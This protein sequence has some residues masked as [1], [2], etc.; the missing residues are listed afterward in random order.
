MNDYIRYSVD[1]LKKEKA[2]LV[3]SNGMIFCYPKNN[4]K[5]TAIKCKELFQIHE[6]TMCF[7]K[8]FFLQMGGFAKNSRGEGARLIQDRKNGVVET[9]IQYCM[10]CVAHDGNT[11]DKEQFNK[12][13]L[14]ANYEG[15]RKEILKEVLNLE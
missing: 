10:I 4:F 15:D 8:K 12:K 3:G 11:V 14:G 1:T 7:T 5:L 6:A 13:E 9:D 2:G